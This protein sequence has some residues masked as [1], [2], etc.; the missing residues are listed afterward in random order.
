M[1]VKLWLIL[2]ASSGFTSFGIFK[3]DGVHTTLMKTT[4]NLNWFNFQALTLSIFE[5]SIQK[6]TQNSQAK[7]S[8]DKRGK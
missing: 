6:A 2:Q 1:Y 4:Q 3:C 8:P 5:R 7:K